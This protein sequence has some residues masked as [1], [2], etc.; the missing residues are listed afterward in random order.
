MISRNVLMVTFEPE[1]IKSLGMNNIE[2]KR[3]NK[4]MGFILLFLIL[5]DSERYAANARCLLY[6]DG[7]A[8][9]MSNVVFTSK[10]LSVRTEY[11]AICMV[12]LVLHVIFFFFLSI[13][14]FAT[15]CSEKKYHA[16]SHYYITTHFAYTGN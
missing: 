13:F 4:M 14:L 6:M 10:T 1:Q 11:F 5:G 2:F 3:H 7:H 15:V 8:S 12:R 16:Y 9:E